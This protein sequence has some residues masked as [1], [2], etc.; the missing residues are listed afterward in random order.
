MKGVQEFQKQKVTKRNE[1][2][3]YTL[4]QKVHLR[5]LQAWFH[6]PDMMW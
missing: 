3:L 5:G 6:R 4:T 2:I 1:Y